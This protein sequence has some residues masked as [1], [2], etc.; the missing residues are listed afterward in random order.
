MRFIFGCR[1]GHDPRERSGLT[2]FKDADTLSSCVSG[3][4]SDGT[5][6]DAIKIHRIGGETRQGDFR[7]HDHVEGEEVARKSSEN[8]IE[9]SRASG[10]FYALQKTPYQTDF[11]EGKVKIRRKS[12]RP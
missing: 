1:H 4:G 12:D 10:C 11:K 5:G 3:A 9:D 6:L 8:V 2:D 7:L